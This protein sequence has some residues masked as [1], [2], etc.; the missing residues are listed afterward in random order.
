MKHSDCLK[1]A[2]K[3]I[4]EHSDNYI[5]VALSNIRNKDNCS[6]VIDIKQRINMLLDN[7]S[8]LEFWLMEN[9]CVALS[10]CVTEEGKQKLRQTRLLW[11]DDMIQYYERRGQ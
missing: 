10:V 2:R 7:L 11:I 8:C 1:E 3:R 5:C 4:V 6:N 9:H